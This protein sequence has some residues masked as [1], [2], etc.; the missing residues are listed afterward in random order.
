[1]FT[2]ANDPLR[3]AS[4]YRTLS[5]FQ[6]HYHH[7]INAITI[8]RSLAIYDHKWWTEEVRLY[9]NYSRTG[10]PPPPPPYVVLLLMFACIRLNCLSWLVFSFMS[11]L[12]E[13][14][15]SAQKLACICNACIVTSADDRVVWLIIRHV[16][17]VLI[18]IKCVVL[19]TKGDFEAVTSDEIV[20]LRV[21]GNFF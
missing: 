21:V 18:S 20:W 10:K 1:M 7:N 8:P 11:V 5:H 16:I 15:T 13:R 3:A 17:G 9:N 14:W 2:Y 19:C 6:N 4:R 12:C